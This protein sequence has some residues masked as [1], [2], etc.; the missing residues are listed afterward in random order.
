MN[1]KQV[2][3][4]DFRVPAG[5]SLAELT[6]ELTVMLGDTDPER[7]DALAYPTLATWVE[8]GVYDDLLPALGDGMAAGLR[9]GIGEEGTD[10][11]FRRSFSALVLA[12]CIT[13][14]NGR[15]LVLGGKVLQWGDAIATWLLRE[16]DV[17]G[18]VPGK[19]WAHAVAHGADALGALAASPHLAKPELTVVLDVVADRLLM[20]L[21]SPFAHGEPDRLVGTTMAVLRR[22][23]VPM[24]VLEPWV[25]RIAAGASPFSR[26]EDSDPFV[27]TAGA[28]AFLRSL[29]LRLALGGRPPTV[30]A[31]LML[32]LVGLLRE[33][34]PA[35]RHP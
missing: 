14:D 26:A 17:R 4:D 23:S 27:P 30:R 16:Q 5:P 34:N 10:S 1:W 22:G 8:R 31:D 29:Y 35:L 19:G 12:E 24:T 15:P 13:R 25:N 11:V 6:E 18:Y 3:D 20:P 9:A 33:T 21:G 2:C 7:R 28:Q 32:V